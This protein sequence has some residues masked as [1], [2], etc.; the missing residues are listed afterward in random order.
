MCEAVEPD[1]Y[2]VLQKLFQKNS[3]ANYLPKYIV[4]RDVRI[5]QTHIL[6]HNSFFLGGV[7]FGSFEVTDDL[8]SVLYLE[9]ASVTNSRHTAHATPSA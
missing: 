9:I 6:V 3:D 2:S 7:W 4:W 1:R 5:F 8:H